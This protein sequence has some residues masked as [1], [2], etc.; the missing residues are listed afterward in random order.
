MNMYSLNLY[1]T[2]IVLHLFPHTSFF[3][4][5]FSFFSQRGFALGI[6]IIVLIPFLLFEE[7]KNKKFL[8]YLFLTLIIALFT[9]FTTK[10]YFKETRP[11]QQL[12][13]K[14][15]HNFLITSSCPTDYSFP[16]GHTLIAFSL[17]ALLAILDK[18]RRYIYYSTALLIGVSRIY[19]QC[20]FFFDVLAGAIIGVLIGLL[21]PKIVGR[22]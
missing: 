14:E 19:L 3:D 4:L 16:S 18:K 8:L 1:L 20:H 17:A 2:N 11:L 21:I 15:I 13:K 6:W 9:T 10:N 12:P 22:K 7:K 5:F